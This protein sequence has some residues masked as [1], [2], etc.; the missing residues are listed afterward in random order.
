MARNIG[1]Q[2]AVV[3]RKSVASGSFFSTATGTQ[4]MVEEC[5][6]SGRVCRA[7]TGLFRA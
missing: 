1:R 6:N 7:A 4:E 5:R 2:C 3:N